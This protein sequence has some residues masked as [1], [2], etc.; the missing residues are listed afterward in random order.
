MQSPQS[1]LLVGLT[2]SAATLIATP[3]LAQTPEPT[4][5]S[6]ILP[7]ERAQAMAQF[8]AGAYVLPP[9]F[10]GSPGPYVVPLTF[11]VIRTSGGTSGIPQSQL[12]QAMIDANSVFAPSGI[13]F[14]LPGPI[15]YI[16]SDF[17][18]FNISGTA[19]I[20]MMRTTNTVPDTINIYFTENLPGLCG[21]SAFTF[22]TVQGIAMAN[23]CTG[24]PNNPST[25]P[26]ELGH[27]FD[28][29]HT[30]TTF[31]GAECVNGSNCATAGDLVCDTPADPRVGS[32][33]VST[34][35]VYTGS[36]TDPCNGSA[37]DPPV[38]NLMSYSRKTCRT[39]FTPGQDTRALATLLNLR[40][41]LALPICSGGVVEYCSPA[42]VNTSGLP[43][44]LSVTGSGLVLDN[45][46]TLRASQLPLGQFGYFLNGQAQGTPTTPMGS[47]GDFCLGGGV[48]RYNG[49][50]DIRFTGTAGAFE[51]SLDLSDT[52]TPTGSI[53]ILSGQTWYYQA[54]FRDIVSGS[55]TSNF[56]NMLSVTFL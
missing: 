14:C 27:Y 32:S 15:D 47:M 11:H 5:G 23:S 26:H 18:Y 22:S 39:H 4:C 56:T 16:D 2:L 41:E 13:E 45:N 53:S 35:C 24:L 44:I 25:F 40:P 46:L 42:A 51:L 20:N 31:N 6:E 50:S 48:G 49:A 17:F 43:G 33:T 10:V 52:P 37:Y 36:A 7:G 55:S 21:I 28:L 29:F 19:D 34:S 54:W 1:K 9:S 3:A 30:H 8:N 38:T 12:D